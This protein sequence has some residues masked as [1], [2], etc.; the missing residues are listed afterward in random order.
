METTFVVYIL[1]TIIFTEAALIWLMHE[2]FWERNSLVSGL[3]NIH[4]KDIVHWEILLK[5]LV[6][7]FVQH[8][9]T[10]KRCVKLDS[11]MLIY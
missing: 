5:N 9:T 10:W 8:D 7:R 11:D 6:R 3:L 2:N 4:D 1:H